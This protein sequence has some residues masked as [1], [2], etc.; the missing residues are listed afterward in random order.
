MLTTLTKDY[1]IGAIL[2]Y[3]HVEQNGT[4][5]RVRFDHAIAQYGYLEYKRV[6]FKNY[7]LKSSEY[8]VFSKS[9]IPSDKCKFNT[10]SDPVFNVYR[11]LF[12]NKDGKKRLPPNIKDLFVRKETLL[13][14]YLDDGHLRCDCRAFR[15]S[16]DNFTP[17]EVETLQ[18]ILWDCFSIKSKIHKAGA[19]RIIYI[20]SK[21]QMSQK[22]NDLLK[23]LCSEIPCML[24]KFF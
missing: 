12:Y 7:A 9:G 21:D 20:G 1:L 18:E 16:T 14:W 6:A 4:N 2:G 15:L 13:I 17:V 24:Y 8:T 3:S 11:Q 10:I 23:P 5:C 22:F 19:N